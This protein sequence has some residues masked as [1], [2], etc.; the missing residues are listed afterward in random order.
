LT[1]LLQQD[2]PRSGDSF[3]VETYSVLA[4][5]RV[6]RSLDDAVGKVRIPT[7]ELSN[8]LLKIL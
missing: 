6:R 4:P 3:P 1:A 5:D 2:H 8:S 7:L